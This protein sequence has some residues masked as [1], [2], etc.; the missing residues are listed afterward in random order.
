M[1]RRFRELFTR[2]ESE[3]MEQ[4]TNNREVWASVVK[5]AKVIRESQSRGSRKWN[6]KVTRKDRESIANY[7]I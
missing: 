4:K 7:L 5:E 3:Q 2:N 1:T 6:S